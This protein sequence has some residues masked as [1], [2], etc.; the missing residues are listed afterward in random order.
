MRLKLKKLLVFGEP[1]CGKST[2]VKP[3]LQFIPM[4]NMASFTKEKAFSTSLL[5]PETLLTHVDEFSEE[6]VSADQAKQVYFLLL[7][8][9][10]LVK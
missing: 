2:I 9:N 5:T 4:E 8:F 6:Y 1:D 7:E 3:V 10:L